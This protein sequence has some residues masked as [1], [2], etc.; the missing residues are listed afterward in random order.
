VAFVFNTP[1]DQSRPG[2]LKMGWRVVGRL[3]VAARPRGPGG[4]LRMAGARQPADLWSQPCAVGLDPAEFFASSDRPSLPAA[5]GARIVTDRDSA[6]LVWRY[7]F[8]PMNYRVWADDSSGAVLVFRLRR[9]GLA[10]ELAMLET[11]GRPRARVITRLLSATRANYA[12]GLGGSRP[13]PGLPLANQGPL[14]TW[15]ALALDRM[16]PLRDWSLVLGDLELF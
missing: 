1:N 3:P 12:I 11:F 7:G 15:R 10:T 16:P 2:Y 9:R 5:D 4:L 14:L 13:R 8:A 6:Y